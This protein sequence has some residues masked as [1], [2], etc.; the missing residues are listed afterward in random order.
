MS[1][2]WTRL[3]RLRERHKV[4]ALEAVAHERRAV[5]QQEA[6]LAQARAALAQQIDAQA[7]LWR[8]TALPGRTFSVE[9][10]RCTSGWSHALDGH[11]A[12]A[13]RHE[14]EALASAAA[15]QQRLDDSRRR[16]R[17]ALGDLQ[18]AERM[19]ERAGAE[20]ARQQDV[21]ADEAAEEAASQA[22]AR[23]AR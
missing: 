21:R 7:T 4:A 23:R 11:I 3:I 14:A 22:W 12:Q 6:G 19:H 16:L 8:D 2:D 18:K 13:A 5:Q 9:A 15:Q 17:A 10:L 1:I 20:R